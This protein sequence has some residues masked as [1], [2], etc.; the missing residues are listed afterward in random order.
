MIIVVIHRT[1]AAMATA[2]A[3]GK[4]LGP[5]FFRSG[6]GPKTGSPYTTPLAHFSSKHRVLKGHAFGIVFL[7][8]R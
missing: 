6:L 2:P 1:L 3:A 8:V 5:P 4:E 7:T